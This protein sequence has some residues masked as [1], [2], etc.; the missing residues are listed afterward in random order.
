MHRLMQRLVSTPPF[1]KK[2]VC[3]VRLATRGVGTW[4]S[5]SVDKWSSDL[6]YQRD[7]CRSGLMMSMDYVWRS[8]MHM[9]ESVHYIDDWSTTN[10]SLSRW[11]TTH[12]A[13]QWLKFQHGARAA[14][15]RMITRGFLFL[16]VILR[17]LSFSR[18]R[19]TR[20]FFSRTCK[21][22]CHAILFGFSSLEYWY[23][24]SCRCCMITLM[25]ACVHVALALRL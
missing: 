10:F 17:Y 23:W 18:G 7:S 13:N 3:N 22:I 6:V 2:K 8:E 4:E 20:F 15:M 14:D 21:D 11:K 5:R 9:S 12:A 1:L 25:V 16:F 24:Y 19:V